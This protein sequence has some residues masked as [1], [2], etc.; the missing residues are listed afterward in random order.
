MVSP[1]PKEGAVASNQ[2]SAAR[3]RH[4]ILYELIEQ[5]SVKITYPTKITYPARSILQNLVPKAHVGSLARGKSRAGSWK[6][7]VLK[8][9]SVYTK[10]PGNPGARQQS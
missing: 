3:Q 8:L 10:E 5:I 1:A 9:C 2:I 6:R 4:F 7:L